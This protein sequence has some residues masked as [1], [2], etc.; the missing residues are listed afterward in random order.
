MLRLE[1]PY[2]LASLWVHCVAVAALTH[3]LWTYLIAPGL[4]ALDRRAAVR[5]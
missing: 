3:I 5:R 1:P 4:Q 2:P